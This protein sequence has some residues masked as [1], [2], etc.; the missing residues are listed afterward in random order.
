MIIIV[1]AELTKIPSRKEILINLPVSQ[2]WCGITCHNPT[3]SNVLILQT[4]KNR[5][6]K[7]LL[8]AQPGEVS[9]LTRVSTTINDSVDM[10]AE[11]AIPNKSEFI[12]EFCI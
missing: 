2:V 11:I 7:K 1:I 3:N 8:N 5:V 12:L 6:I 9:G 4:I 10:S